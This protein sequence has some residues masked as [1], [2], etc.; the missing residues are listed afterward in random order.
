MGIF[1]FIQ[2]EVIKFNVMG[3]MEKVNA[4]KERIAKRKEEQLKKPPLTKEAT[5]Q[6]V[7]QVY[8]KLT[9]DE[10]KFLINLIGKS[11]FIGKDIQI[12]Y[13]IVAKLQNKLNL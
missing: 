12:L 2:Q 11:E 6:K 4:K 1:T 7:D 13:S 9:N 8:T 3:I 10:I 5:K